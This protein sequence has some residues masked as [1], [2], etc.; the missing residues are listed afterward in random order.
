M[1]HLKTVQQI[2]KIRKS[3]R[4]ASQTLDFIGEHLVPGVVTKGLDKL[5]HDFIVGHGGVPATLGYKGY[6]ASSCISINEV[7]VHGIPDGRRVK[8]GDLVKIDVT[9]ILDGYFGDNARTYLVGQVPEEGVRLATATREALNLA[10]AVVRPGAR[11]GDVGWAIQSHVES[12]GF[13]VVRQFVG[14]GVGL[15]FHEKPSV[16]HHGRQGSGLKLKS[17]MVFTIEPMINAGVYEIKIL[18]DGW[19]AVTV[20]GKLSAQF[21]HTVA[22]TADGA[23]VLTLS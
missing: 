15:A 8:D 16:P 22:V 17:G 5:I 12:R 18:N 13:S 3:G 6:P 21:E 1:I 23:E 7:V 11:L 9:T 19:T 10:I 14:H 4:L 2:D 20:D